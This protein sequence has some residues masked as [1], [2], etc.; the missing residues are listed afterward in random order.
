MKRGSWAAAA[1][2]PRLVEPTSVTVRRLAARAQDGLGLGAEPRD[3]DGDDGEIGIGDGL[4]ERRGPVVDGAALGREGEGRGVGVE[5]RDR[6]DTRAL[7]GEAD[8]GAD[9]AGADDR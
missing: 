7:G 4:V 6:L 8:G 2:T 9:E 5:P 1:A 3:G